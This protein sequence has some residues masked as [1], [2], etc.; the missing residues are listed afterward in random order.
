MDE[1]EDLEY[2][3]ILLG[4]SSVN[5]TGLF[6]KFSN[7]FKEKNV[8][9]I[10]IDRKTLELKCDLEDKEGKVIS[11][12]AKINLTDTAGQERY[13][14]LTKSYYKN[15]DGALILYDITVK[16]TFDNVDLWIKSIEE[17]IDIDKKNYVIFLLGTN[18]DLVQ[19]GKKE[20][21]VSEEEA[22]LK[23]EQNKLHWVGE[24][25]IKEFPEEELKEIIAGFIR[26]FYKYIGIKNEKNR[27]LDI[28]QYRKK[29]KRNKK[30]C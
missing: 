13:R 20:R 6:K 16:Q 26:I 19:S 22:I 3:L 4:D 9:T 12:I 10:G 1:N 11:K 18:I 30:F 14:A 29:E 8:S 7:T 2:N 23:C 25:S 27:T 17:V 5:K 15:S 28:K 21:E 24:I